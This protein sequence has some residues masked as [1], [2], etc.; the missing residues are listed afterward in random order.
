MYLYEKKDISNKAQ[1]IR[2]KPLKNSNLPGI[3]LEKLLNK[4]T[5]IQSKK[6]DITESETNLALSITSNSSRYKCD[7]LG[8]RSPTLLNDS[9]HLLFS[10]KSSHFN[11]NNVS[12]TDVLSKLHDTK[13][14]IIKIVE[15][16]AEVKHQ[17]VKQ[18][19]MINVN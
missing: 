14:N 13:P 4:S 19:N 1:S 9:S 6:K 12:R 2:N 8:I 10:Q 17:N 16:L 18:Q 7:E 5:F 11:P 15:E 3:Q